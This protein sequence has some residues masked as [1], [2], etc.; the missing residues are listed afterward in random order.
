MRLRLF[1]KGCPSLW[2]PPPIFFWSCPK[3]NPPEG[4]LLPLWGNSPS[5][6]WT[7]QKK[8]RYDQQED[9]MV[10]LFVVTWVVRIGAVKINKPRRPCAGPRQLHSCVPT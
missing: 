9:R 2:L 8:K 7:V 5:G 6:P 3:E 1:C 4:L 10:L